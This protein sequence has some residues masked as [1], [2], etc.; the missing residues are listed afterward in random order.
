MLSHLFY[1][2]PYSPH[3]KFLP[4]LPLLFLSGC[5]STP[6]P[7]A[8]SELCSGTKRPY[9]ING[10]TYYP[11]DH[12]EYD[13][14][15]VASW[16]GPG[17]HNRPGSCG[18]LFDQNAWTAAH[19]TLP[20]PSVVEVTNRDNG[21]KITLVVN[22]R[23]PFV[24]NRI[25]D[26]SKRAAEELGTHGKG[27]GNVRVQVL[28]EKSKALANYLKQFGRYGID[29]SGR[30]WDT[31]Y[32][33]EIAEKHHDISEE[34]SSPA[35]IPISM[36]E[37]LQKE[38]PTSL[39]FQEVIEDLSV[40]EIVEVEEVEVPQGRKREQKQIALPAKQPD[41]GKKSSKRQVKTPVPSTKKSSY[42]SH[43]V[44]V[45]SFVQRTN[46]HKL[47]KKLEKYGRTQVIS[48]GKNFYTVQLGPYSSQKQAN[49]ILAIVAKG[50]YHGA[51]VVR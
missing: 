20:I 11:Q 14:E 37:E 13:E 45:G 36:T 16:Y 49:Q 48:E 34:E 9:Q 29:P 25:I 39:A 24:D 35:P 30:S 19:K 21:R 10:K 31:I 33:Q 50:G 32:R 7:K 3:L 27:L 12:Y 18:S 47:V 51:R 4:L 44:K 1:Q 23:G 6:P 41:N 40:E 38:S 15:G 42:S 17:F 43:F 22:D 5:S 2:R 8:A 28:P 26:L 46:A